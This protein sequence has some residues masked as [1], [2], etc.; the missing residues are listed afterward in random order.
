[1][2]KAIIVDID[3]TIAQKHPD[4][5][6]Y[7]LNNVGLDLP[8]LQTISTITD[9]IISPKEEEWIDLLFV[10]GRQEICKKDTIDWLKKHILTNIMNEF[11]SYFCND[12]EVNLANWKY[13][14]FMRK[15][16]DNRDDAIVKKEIYDQQI[17]D[18]YD[19]IAV[20]D[21]RPKVLRMWRELGLFTFNCCQHEKEF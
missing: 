3:G 17:K 21:D 5:D 4:R 16:N 6:I 14:L 1:M 12:G 15:I 18:K 20:F 9:I 19:V 7:D 8:I 13:E 2:R 11:Y 10:S